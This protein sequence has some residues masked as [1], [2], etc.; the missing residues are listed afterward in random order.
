MNIIF[1]QN[2]NS[3]EKFNSKTD[4][5]YIGDVFDNSLLNEIIE[6]KG[7]PALIFNDSFSFIELDTKIDFYTVN[8]FLERD[9][10]DLTFAD[11]YSDVQTAHSVNFL[12]N[13]KQINRFLTL[14]FCEMFELDANYTWSGIGREFDLSYI[15]NE[16]KDQTFI[17]ADDISRILEPL[18]SA[19]RWKGMMKN[20]NN[21]SVANYGGN[22]QAWNSGIIDIV[23]SSAVSLI[24]ES[25]WTQT[26]A[27]FTEKTLF[28]VLGLTF[29]IWVGGVR[30]ATEWKKMGFDIFDDIIDHSYQDKK[31]LIE[32]CWY[33]F[34]LNLD[35]LKNKN[36]LSD[37]RQRCLPRLKSN[38]ELLRYNI[39]NY[40]NAVIRSWPINIQQYA[41]IAYKRLRS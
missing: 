7:K 27:V 11:V 39:V 6:Q 34:Y 12:I 28:S 32:R 23:S 15:L 41:S 10:A 30:Q 3:I 21:A 35:L 2:L 16:L 29:P 1:L 20:T 17:S 8:V 13:K 24:S 22:L 33:A 14:K 37:I 25:V 19:P 36:K 38:R 18:N 4:I 9:L 40:N 26:A 5:L 31:T